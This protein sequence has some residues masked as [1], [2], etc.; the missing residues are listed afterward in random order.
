MKR[1]NIFS[2]SNVSAD[3][4]APVT[5]TALERA[6]QRYGDDLYRLALLLTPDDASAATALRNAMRRLVDT[7]PAAL[8]EP[9]MIT[10]LVAAL[11][12]DRRRVRSRRLPAWAQLPAARTEAPLIAALAHVP[13]PQRL[14]LGL[15]ILRGLEA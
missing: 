3:E 4:D 2:H 1:A 12:S 9:A 6:I 7:P 11:P 8:T 10:A 13:R 14:A 15:T 5:A